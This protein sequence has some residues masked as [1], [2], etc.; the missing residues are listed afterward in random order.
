MYSIL[1]GFSVIFQDHRRVL[2]SVFMIEIATSV[3][4]LWRWVTG[5]N[6]GIRK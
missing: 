4:S 5:R 1:G 6:F 3:Q 2:L